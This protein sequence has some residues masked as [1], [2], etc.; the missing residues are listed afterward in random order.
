MA[1]RP[2]G[3]EEQGSGIWNKKILA[4]WTACS[5]GPENMEQLKQDELLGGGVV[6]CGVVSTGPV[7]GVAGD[8]PVV[9]VSVDVSVEASADV[10]VGVTDVDS[11]V[12]PHV[13][14]Q[15]MEYF[16]HH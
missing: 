11:A 7:V 6:C 16:Q 12:I 8:P 3:W 10:V 14:P 5:V 9:T 1:P 2:Q 15:E 13:V 4:T